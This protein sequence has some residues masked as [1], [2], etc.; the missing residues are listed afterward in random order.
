MNTV[1]NSEFFFS[2][3]IAKRKKTDR[4]HFISLL[5]YSKD[6]CEEKDSSALYTN[7]SSEISCI[8]QNL[9]L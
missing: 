5:D 1:E 2:L 3:I 8:K 4:R 7:D 9:R 6:G